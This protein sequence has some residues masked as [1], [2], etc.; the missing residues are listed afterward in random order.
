MDIDLYIG[1]SKSISRRVKY[2]KGVGGVSAG[3]AFDTYLRI[4]LNYL[5]QKCTNVARI[6]QKADTCDT[7][8]TPLRRGG[9]RSYSLT[10]PMVIGQFQGFATPFYFFLFLAQQI[11]KLSFRCRTCKNEI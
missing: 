6:P 11:I 2:R 3:V 8:A 5:R 7:L 9:R 10:V 1:K 4:I